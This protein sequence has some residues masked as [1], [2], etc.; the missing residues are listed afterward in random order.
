MLGLKNCTP[1][2]LCDNIHSEISPVGD[3]VVSHQQEFTVLNSQEGF[4]KSLPEISLV[5]SFT[6][7][8]HPKAQP[9]EFMPFSHAFAL[10]AL[11][12]VRHSHKLQKGGT[13]VPKQ[14]KY[15]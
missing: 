11:N 2:Q 8:K 12:A 14:R 5:L 7:L 15:V 13:L 4:G 6:K 10:N 1:H 3:L 9:S